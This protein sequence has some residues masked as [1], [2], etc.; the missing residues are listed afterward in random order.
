MSLHG[1]L[2]AVVTGPR[3]R[4][5]GARPPPTAT[6]CTSTWS[7]RPPPAPSPSPR[8]PA[9]TGRPVLA[10]TATGPGG[11]G[12]GRG[13]ALAAARRTASWSTRP[14]RRCRTSGSRPRSRHRRPPPRRAAP[15]RPPARRTTRRPAR[16]R[17]S[18]RRS[19]PCCSRRS[20]GSAT[21]SRWPCAPGGRAD[22]DEVVDGAGGRRV[23]PRRT[24]R[25]AR[26]VRR[27]R[28]HPR[29]LPADRGAPPAGGVLGRRRRGDPLLQGRRPAL[30]GGRRARAVGAAL[31][32]A[33]ADRR[34]TGSGP[35]PS[36]RTHPELGELLGKIAEGI[37]VEGMESLAPVLVDDMELL[38]DVL[39][40]GRH[41]RGLRPGAGA[42]PGGGPGGDRA[43]VPAGVLGGHRR[44]RRGARSTSARPP[45]GASRTSATGPASWA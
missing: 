13:A 11:R 15:A 31:P 28:R 45:C 7:A 18:S 4:G 12:P 40:E 6:A 25:E 5:S 19:A 32:R 23:L 3:A 27:T 36:P 44:R 33:A 26:R 37:A 39:P 17:S 24:G 35:R 22:L 42:D 16:S 1:L 34:R 20:R 29:R 43:G 21:W 41:G 38:L 8:S 2:D 10:V 14:G 30:P 9:Q